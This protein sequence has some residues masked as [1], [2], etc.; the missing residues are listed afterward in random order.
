MP[1][2]QTGRQ[3]DKQTDNQTDRQTDRQTDTHTLI[4]PIQIR[5]NIKKIDKTHTHTINYYRQSIKP[6]H[7]ATT[8]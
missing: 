4:K 8:N 5:A 3:T 1:E 2:R 7:I 6:M